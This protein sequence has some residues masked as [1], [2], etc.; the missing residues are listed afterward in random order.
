M[1]QTG[2]DG[3]LREGSGEERGLLDTP[4]QELCC[5]L[6][7]TLGSRHS[8][9]FVQKATQVC[10]IQVRDTQALLWFWPPSL[11]SEAWTPFFFVKIPIFLRKMPTLCLS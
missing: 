11:F 10:N 5:L 4:T 3:G 6:P 8:S 9:A 2:W 1:L 7:C